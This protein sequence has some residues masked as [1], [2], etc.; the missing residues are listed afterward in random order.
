MVY[1]ICCVTRDCDFINQFI[2]YHLNLGFD[3]ITIYDN[4]S[5]IPVKYEDNRVIIKRYEG[6]YGAGYIPYNEHA[7]QYEN[8][9][10]W[11]AYIDEDEFIET[12]GLSIQEAMI[13]FQNYDSLAL[14]WR[15]FGDK[16]DKE[17]ISDKIYENMNAC[18]LRNKH[19]TFFCP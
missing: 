19:K 12:R 17:E 4:L 2:E 9:N 13:P 1:S 5:I 8:E 3:R 10:G 15:I 7:K 6:F 16:I 11:T 14:D 18:I